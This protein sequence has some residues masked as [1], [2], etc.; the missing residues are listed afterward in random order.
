MTDKRI[1]YMDAGRP[2]LV[3]PAATAR[4]EDETDDAFIDRIRA[5]DVP[6]EAIDLRF[7]DLADLPENMSA[8]PVFFTAWKPDGA[9]VS[10]DM[11]KARD[12]WRDRIRE[13][14]APLLTALDVEYQRADEQGDATAKRSIAARKQVLRDAPAHPDIEAAATP[15]ALKAVWPLSE[16]T[17]P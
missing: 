9:G 5:K 3:I 14:R 8:G 15:E 16:E 10:I 12:I 6:P 1:F 2:R 4:L 11:P 13:A 17:R 7:I